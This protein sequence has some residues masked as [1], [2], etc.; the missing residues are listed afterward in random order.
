MALGDPG[1]VEAYTEAARVTTG[2]RHRLVRARLARAAAVGGDL[3]TARSALAGLDLEDDE[4]DASLL[5]GQGILAYFTGDME[6]AR[7]VAAEARE[8]LRGIDDPWHLVDLV[9]LHGLAGPPSRGVVPQLPHRAATDT[10]TRAAGRR[11]LR[12]APVRRGEP[13]LRPR[14]VSRDHRRGRAAPAARPHGR[15]AAGRGL[16]LRADRRGGPDDGRPDPRGSGARRGHHPQRGHSMRSA[17]RRTACSGSPRCD[18]PRAAPTRPGSCSTRHCCWRGGP[19]WACTS[20]NAS[21][22]P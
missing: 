13:A 11:P 5:L 3:A 22:G 9:G 19:R 6:T 16:R 7:R 1:A 21:S 15:C 12:C 17:A 20:C 8:R 18:L 4:A 10:R 2:T 14:A